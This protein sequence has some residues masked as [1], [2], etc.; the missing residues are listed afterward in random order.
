MEDISKTQH[1][2]QDIKDMCDECIKIV[3]DEN[4][5]HRIDNRKKNMIFNILQELNVIINY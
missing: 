4:T 3:N 2:L 5:S 1:M